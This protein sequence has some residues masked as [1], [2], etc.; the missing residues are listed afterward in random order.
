MHKYSAL[1]VFLKRSP[2]N[3]ILD[4]VRESEGIRTWINGGCKIPLPYKLKRKIVLDF[5]R[6]LRRNIFIETGTFLGDM[7]RDVKNY[8][9]EVHSIELE[10]RLH[11]NA[12]RLFAQDAHVHIHHGDSASILPKLV[13]GIQE[14]IFFWLDAHY[15]GGI[16][17]RGDKFTPIEE[18]LDVILRHPVNGHVI[19]IDDAIYFGGTRDHPTLDEVV[20]LVRS[21]KPEYIVKHEDD[22]IQIF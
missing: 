15:S 4:Y 5:T 12:Q 7:V 18:E 13:H 17:G 21:H 2:L 6:R 14:P 11:E 3:A 16:S 19:L 10:D 8:Y 20:Q 22:M 1:E 9:R